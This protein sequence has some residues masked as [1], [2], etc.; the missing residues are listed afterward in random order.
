AD[1]GEVALSPSSSLGDKARV[2]W[3]TNSQGMRDKVY[4]SYKP[5][6]TFRIALVGD[7]IS[8]GCGVSIDQRFESI[9]EYIWNLRSTSAFAHPVEILNF[10]VP[11]HSPGQRWH[12]FSQIGWAMHPDLVIYESTAA[13]FHWDERRMRYLLGQGLG[14][15]SPIYRQALLSTGLE[16]SHD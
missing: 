8:A 14:W 11:G 5:N 7:S 15:F 9:L 16:P 6:G 4:V 3:S 12:H 1:L 13:D 10:A 2:I